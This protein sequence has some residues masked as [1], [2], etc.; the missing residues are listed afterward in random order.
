MDLLRVGEAVVEVLIVERFDLLFRG[1]G[2][3]LEVAPA[4]RDVA[5]RTVAGVL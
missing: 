4:V 2:H 1:L 5:A 3:R